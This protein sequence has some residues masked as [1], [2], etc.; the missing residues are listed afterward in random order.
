MYGDTQ[1]FS[2]TTP[3]AYSTVMPGVSL[4]SSVTTPSGPTRSSASATASPITGSSLAAIVATCLSASRPSTGRA[5][6]RSSAERASMASSM[7][8]RRSIGFAPSSR[9]R[10]PSRTIACASSVAVVVPSPV[11]SE[12]LFATSRTS[13]APMLRYW[14]ESSISRAIETPSLVIVG[15]PA[16]RSS[17]T[18][19]PFGPSVTLTVLASASTPS[20]SSR[21]ASW[22]KYRRLPMTPSLGR[23]EDAAALQPPLVEVRHRVVDRVQRIRAGVERDLA[24]GGQR[25]EVLQV[26]VGADEV[27]DEGDLAR[28]D[29]DRRH[30]DVLAVADDV[31]EAAVLHH[32]DAVLD[33]ALLA[34]E[35]DDRL[36]A[37]PVGELGDE[38]ALGAV[39]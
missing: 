8:R 13:W 7:P 28:D 19:R 21:R 22:L 32:G 30:V 35:V 5:I 27:P 4:S 12:V 1:P 29:F 18:L 34:D 14:S 39:R 17:T 9:A 24:L 38:V 23:D 3:S 20:W 37:H 31:V 6:R 25:H 15:G 11:R 26:D 36:G 16:S 10:I 33:R 2:T